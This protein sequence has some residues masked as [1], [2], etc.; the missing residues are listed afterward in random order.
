MLRLV[1]L[2]RTDV[3]EECSV[4]VMANVVTSSPILVTLTMEVL[5]SSEMSVLTRAT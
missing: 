3:S 2:V 4:I 1:A 5:S